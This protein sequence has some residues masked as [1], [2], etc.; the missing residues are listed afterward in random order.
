M[1]FHM[2]KLPKDFRLVRSVPQKYS[3]NITVSQ[4]VRQKADQASE[5]KW[6]HR[7]V[8]ILLK[9][10]V[11][12]C[13]DKNMTISSRQCP[14]PTSAPESPLEITCGSIFLK[15]I[16]LRLSI[17]LKVGCAHQAF[18]R[19][20][21]STGC[22]AEDNKCDRLG[23]SFLDKTRHKKKASCC[24]DQALVR[25]LPNVHCVGWFKKFVYTSSNSRMWKQNGNTTIYVAAVCDA[26]IELY[27]SVLMAGFALMFLRYC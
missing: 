17:P 18:Q 14:L 4:H 6:K 13:L 9:V 15:R 5:R 26:G 20:L 21:N 16:L 3:R 12:E 19:F 23:R 24:I 7:G 10:K 2:I 25:F 22:N 8:E 1:F 11:V 27:A